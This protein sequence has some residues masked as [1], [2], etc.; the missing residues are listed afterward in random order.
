MSYAGSNNWKMSPM[1]TF[2][3]IRLCLGFVAKNRFLQHVEIVLNRL[4]PSHLVRSFTL[5][6]HHGV[7]SVM[8]DTGVSFKYDARVDRVDLPFR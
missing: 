3:G 6:K 2:V 4:V 7:D 1:E 8:Y 5:E